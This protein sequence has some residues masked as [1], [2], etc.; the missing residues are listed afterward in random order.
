VIP[1][2]K[3]IAL[4]GPS[5]AGKTTLFELLQRF[6]DPQQGKIKFNDTSITQLK[7]KDPQSSG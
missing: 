4:V 6:Y 2:G 1:T 7:H 5:G 3:T